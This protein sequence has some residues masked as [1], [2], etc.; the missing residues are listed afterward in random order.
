MIENL[1]D[2]DEAFV[3]EVDVDPAKPH[4]KPDAT[5]YLAQISSE[6]NLLAPQPPEDS[7]AVIEKDLAM[8]VVP[9]GTLLADLLQRPNVQ[10][11]FGREG[12]SPQAVGKGSPIPHTLSEALR[13]GGC[14]F[15][16]LWR[17]SLRLRSMEGGQDLQWIPNG[18]NVRRASKSLNWYQLHGFTWPVSPKRIQK[19]KRIQ[20]NRTEYDYI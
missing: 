4:Q 17:L 9:D 14:V 19:I 10:E 12:G 5:S 7:A 1:D 13:L 11:P 16:R 6:A 2:L 20:K 3:E 8:D 15:N 18:K